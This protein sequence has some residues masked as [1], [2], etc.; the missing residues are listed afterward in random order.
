MDGLILQVSKED[1]ADILSM[2]NGTD[3]LFFKQCDDPEY[4]MMIADTDYEIACRREP[5]FK[6]TYQLEDAK[7]FDDNTSASIDKVPPEYQEKKDKYGVYRDMYGR[8]RSIKGKVIPVSTIHIRDILQRASLCK[9]SFLC[10]PEH[11]EGFTQ[12]TP[13]DPNPYSRE[14]WMRGLRISTPFRPWRIL[15]TTLP[16]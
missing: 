8:P 10:L 5:Y 11:R 1:I 13:S 12:A 6:Y 14:R 4:Q 3:N 7:S 9:P 15:Q 16:P 2:A